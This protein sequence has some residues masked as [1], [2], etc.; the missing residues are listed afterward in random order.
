MRVDGRASVAEVMVRVEQELSESKKGDLAEA[1]ERLG[2][3][4]EKGAEL[5]AE[6]KHL[7]SEAD[8]LATE[9]RN[10]EQPTSFFGKLFNG[11]SKA[12][13]AAE[14]TH[15]AE[16]KSLE[17][18]Q[19][20]LELAKEQQAQKEALEKMQSELQRHTSAVG[21]LNELLQEQA[22]HAAKLL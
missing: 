1:K 10:V 11:R 4:K 17:A 22:R 8:R 3:N 12:R 13:E 19:K 20:K 6:L 5:R 21:N 16:Q 2:A 18:E 9:A 15:K 14:K 7:R